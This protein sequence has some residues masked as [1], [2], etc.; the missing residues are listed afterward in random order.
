MMRIFCV[1]RSRVWIPQ[2]ISRDYVVD[3]LVILYGLRHFPIFEFGK[4]L[5]RNFFETRHVM[6]QK[7]GFY[8]REQDYCL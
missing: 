5:R 3:L 1:S 7:Y 8:T 2:F 6:E 4:N